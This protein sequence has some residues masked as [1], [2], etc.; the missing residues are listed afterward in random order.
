MC[1]LLS[2]RG[3]WIKEILKRVQDD[4]NIFLKRTYSHI[5]L[6][7]YSPYKKAAFTLAEVLV[8][9]GI[10][11]VVSAMTVPTLMQNHQRKVY[12]TQ[13]HKIY[14][15]LQQAALQY[16]ND[17]NALNLTEAGINSEDAAA[18]FVKTYFNV[19]QDCGTDQTPCFPST[20]EYKKLSG[21]T[22]TTWYPKRHFVL[23]D[24]T[25]LGTYY[26]LS[27][28][29][30]VEFWVDTNGTKGPNIVGRDF[31]VMYMY[32]NG[33]LDDLAASIP[34]SKE[35]RETSFTNICMSDSGSNYHGCFGK[36][37]NDNWEMTY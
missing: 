15:Q 31:F 9:L 20:G 29:A 4:I 24:G 2:H 36:L 25:S 22:I 30:I 34:M 12:V 7:T 35:Q 8:T 18:N 23:A 19:I 17:R 13:L 3:E 11:G 14:N 10:I 5:N 26:S 33:G 32:N 1:H 37:L 28:G 21:A 27:N 6:F 16:T